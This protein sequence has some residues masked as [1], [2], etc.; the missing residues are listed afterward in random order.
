[1]VE[2]TVF[3]ATLV[4]RYDS[5]LPSVDWELEFE[6]YFNLWPIKL[7]LKVWHTGTD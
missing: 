6:E 5:A 1:M 4:A 7:P 3:L 2:Q